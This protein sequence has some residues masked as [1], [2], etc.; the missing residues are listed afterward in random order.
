[1]H[2]EFDEN[3]AYVNSRFLSDDD[4]MARLVYP[5]FSELDRYK[6]RLIIF[7]YIF[8]ATGVLID[9]CMVLPI[10][11]VDNFEEKSRIA[12]NYFKEKYK[13]RIV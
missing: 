11:S 4:Q 2:I 13:P 5:L 6:K 10:G 1:M 8:Y 3:I 7:N 9:H 12:Y